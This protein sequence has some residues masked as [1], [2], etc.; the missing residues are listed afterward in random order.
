MTMLNGYA[1]IVHFFKSFE[2]WKTEPHDE[3][4]NNGAFCLAERGRLYAV[5]LPHGGDIS[6]K[7]DP[8]RYQARLF[9]PRSGQYSTAPTAEGT[10][11]RSPLTPDGE[12]WVFLLTRI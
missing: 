2:W 6:V 7:L 1:H 10:T 3:L 12:D 5:Y 8:G 9:N 11:W 4:V